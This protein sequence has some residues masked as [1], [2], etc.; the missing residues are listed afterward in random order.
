[1]HGGGRYAS[2]EIDHPFR[3]RYAR[4]SRGCHWHPALTRPLRGRLSECVAS[5]NQRSLKKAFIPKQDEGSY[6]HQSTTYFTDQHLLFPNAET[7]RSLLLV[8]PA[9]QER[10]SRQA[11]PRRLSPHP[12]RL[13]FPLAVLSPSSHLHLD[14][15]YF[16]IAEQ[17]FQIIF[18][19]GI[20][21]VAGRTCDAHTD[22]FS[23][24]HCRH[25]SMTA[26]CCR[27]FLS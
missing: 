2:F 1:M 7:R 5:I 16:S 6:A 12:A 8:Q 21:H 4:H 24:P 26:S 22:D 15:P 20:C 9:T 19:T 25:S 14:A 10:S 3:H 17:R 13:R 27:V 18:V 23:H 11:T